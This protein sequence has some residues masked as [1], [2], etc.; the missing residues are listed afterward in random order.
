MIKIGIRNN[1]LYPLMFVIFLGARRLVK[2]ILGKTINYQSPFLLAF[3]MFFAE[4]VI[5]GIY[6]FYL[7]RKKKKIEKSKVMGITLIKNENELKRHDS[8][9]KIIILMILAAVIEFIGAIVRRYAIQEIDNRYD[10]D[11]EGEQINTRLRSFEI[12][13]SSLLS[14]LILSIKIY[15]HH[16]VTIIIIGICLICGVIIELFKNMKIIFQ[17]IL[18]LITSTL[19][20]AFL[21]I[22]EKHL[23][24]K[25]FVNVFKITTFEGFIDTILILFSYFLKAPKDEIKDLFDLGGYKKPIACILLIIYGVLSFYKNIYRRYT[26]NEYSPMTRALAE[27]IFDP[28]II[29]CYYVDSGEYNNN[30][31]NLYYTLF[32]LLSIIMVFCSLVYNE[33][34][35]L[36]FCNME[37]DTYIEICKRAKEKDGTNTGYNNEEENMEKMNTY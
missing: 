9:L 22:I 21:D 10:V 2:A 15:R 13:I 33:F 24:E 27:S 36:Y 17:S 35:V 26:L 34:L 31:N 1:L 7:N 11:D 8:D 25:D 28:I 14:Y 3:L 5:G 4:F 29:F 32:F 37:H 20:R 18:I 12:I 6:A 16:I 23:F 30:D 19:S